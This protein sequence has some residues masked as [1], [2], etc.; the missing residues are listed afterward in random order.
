LVIN[1]NETT[2]QTV[3]GAGV[4]E[5]T[6]FPVEAILQEKDKRNHSLNRQGILNV[7]PNEQTIINS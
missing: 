1:K 3:H 6:A 2:F 4:A 5:E 7:V